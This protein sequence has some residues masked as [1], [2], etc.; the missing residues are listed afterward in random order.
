MASDATTLSAR[1]KKSKHAEAEQREGLPQASR[2][3]Q[4]YSDDAGTVFYRFP[5]LEKD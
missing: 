2:G 4:E 3:R 1:R 5:G